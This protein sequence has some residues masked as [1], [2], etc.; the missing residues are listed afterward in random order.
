VQAYT[1]RL[2]LAFFYHHLS[3]IASSDAFEDQDWNLFNDKA[4]RKLSLP[5]ARNELNA[6]TVE[7]LMGW[8]R[9][10]AL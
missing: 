2:A 3:E 1:S 9:R 4:L 10:P 5:H 7:A 8:S 6:R